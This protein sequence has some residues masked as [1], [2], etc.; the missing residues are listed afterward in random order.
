MRPRHIERHHT[1]RIGWLRTAVLGENDGI[2][3]TASRC[4]V[5]LLHRLL[6]AI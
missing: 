4:W 6:T 5:L 2:V 1:E 3:S